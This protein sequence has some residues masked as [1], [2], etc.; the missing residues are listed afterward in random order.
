[1]F[2]TCACAPADPLREH[3]ASCSQASVPHF[4]L[5][6][7]VLDRPAALSKR[8][9]LAPT[10]TSPVSQVWEK[11]EGARKRADSWLANQFL[12][13][14][15]SPV[16][17]QLSPASTDAAPTTGEGGQEGKEKEKDLPL[18]IYESVV[19]LVAGEAKPTFVPVPYE[20]VTGEAERVAVEGVSKPEAGADGGAQGNRE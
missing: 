5:S 3:S 10:G 11:G 14:N 2:K 9:G 20:V 19:E 13:Y 6:R 8:H 12:E 15:E 17:L 16:F 4:R 7:L 18:A 1:M